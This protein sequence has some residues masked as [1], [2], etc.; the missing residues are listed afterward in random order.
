MIINIFFFSIFSQFR[1]AVRYT[2]RFVSGAAVLEVQRLIQTV[3]ELLPIIL[4]LSD[5]ASTEELKLPSSW[6]N[7]FKRL[8]K[9]SRL[10]VHQDEKEGQDKER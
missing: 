1:S 7:E 10:V 4:L 2:Q 8:E 6:Q 5:I 3:R 9:L